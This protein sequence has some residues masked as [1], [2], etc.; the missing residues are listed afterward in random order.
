MELDD[1]SDVNIATRL[2]A[3]PVDWHPM[4]VLITKTLGILPVLLVIRPLRPEFI[5]PIIIDNIRERNLLN[6][7]S[8]MK[9]SVTR[10]P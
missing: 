3:N 6:V 2:L 7:A 1:K 9:P 4:F 5:W 8:A 10:L